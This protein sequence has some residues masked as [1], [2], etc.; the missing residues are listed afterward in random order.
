[1]NFISREEELPKSRLNASLLKLEPFDQVISPSKVLENLE[2]YK[3][4]DVRMSFVHHLYLNLSEINLSKHPVSSASKRNLAIE[5]RFMDKDETT[6]TPGL[7]CLYSSSSSTSNFCDSFMSGVTYHATK[8][9]FNEEIKIALPLEIRKNHHL[10][11][12]I[13]HINCKQ[14]KKEENIKTPIAYAFM[15]LLYEENNQYFF[16]KDG[17]HN[18][19]CALDLPPKYTD[20]NID[21]ETIKWVTQRPIFSL[22]TKLVSSILDQ[23]IHLQNYFSHYDPSSQHFKIELISNLRLC[24]T[25]AVFSNLYLLLNSL[26]SILQLSDDPLLL[27]KTFLALVHILNKYFFFVFFFFID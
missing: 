22:S 6:S 19:P 3:V 23:D 13:Y 20:P 15:P 14:K 9:T 2:S 27:K 10:L 4:S 1:M 21:V 12:I 18:L 16:I 17:E 26:T 8:A 11:F 5:V 24:N 7:N 25:N